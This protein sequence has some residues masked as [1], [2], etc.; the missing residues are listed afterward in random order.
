[1]VR[2]CLSNFHAEP[3]SMP[4][5]VEVVNRTATAITLSWDAPLDLGGRDDVSYRVCYQEDGVEAE[6]ESCILTL[7][8]LAVISG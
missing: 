8:T 3:P 5:N 4:R 2:F 6:E 7:L 1:M